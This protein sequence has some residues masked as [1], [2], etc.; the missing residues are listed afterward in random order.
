[1][2]LLLCINIQL[3]DGRAG[4]LVHTDTQANRMQS[5]FTCVTLLH[6]IK[7][8]IRVW[9]FFFLF[10]FI[11][12]GAAV[13]SVRWDAGTTLSAWQIN[14]WMQS[15]VWERRVQT[16]EETRAPRT[17][18]DA[19]DNVCVINF[20]FVQRPS[21]VRSLSLSPPPPLFH[22]SNLSLLYAVKLSLFHFSLSLSLLP[23]AFRGVDGVLPWQR[24]LAKDRAVAFTDM[25]K[26]SLIKPKRNHLL[27]WL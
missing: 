12:W 18:T 25:S 2:W 27:F 1:M 7:D 22:C 26:R 24:R 17:P 10:F 8:V 4:H 19:N 16:A 20:S 5:F 13:P 3:N 23:A 14:N 11:M 9:G 21:L 6:C 15:E